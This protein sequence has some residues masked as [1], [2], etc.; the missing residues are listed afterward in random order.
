MPQNFTIGG[1]KRDEI[2][3]IAGEQQVPPVLRLMAMPLP[4]GIRGAKRVDFT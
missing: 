2:L 1:A 4:L 3:P